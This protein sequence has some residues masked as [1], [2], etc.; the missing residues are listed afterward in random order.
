[1]M[2]GRQ[3]EKKARTMDK[4]HLIFRI[5]RLVRA[6]ESTSG[7]GEL[8]ISARAILNFIGEAE[9]EGRSLNVSDV[10]KGPGFGTAPTVY[11]RLSELEKAGWVKAVPD[12]RDGR[13]KRV[14]LTPLAKRTYARMSADARKLFTTKEA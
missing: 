13:A 14:L 11:T 4:N 6:I 8:D 2:S 7:L 10:V 12:P 9:A 3:P 5:T 1:M